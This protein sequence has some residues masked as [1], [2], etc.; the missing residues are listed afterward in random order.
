MTGG[1]PLEPMRLI[2]ATHNPAKAREV[3]RLVAGLAEVVPLPVDQPAIAAPEDGESVEEIAIAKAVFW[4]RLLNRGEF[5]VAS[6]GGL[7]IPGLGHRWNPTRTR[8]F[9]GDAATDLERAE[10]LLA[11]AADI[12]DDRRQIAWQEALAVARDGV[13]LASWTAAGDPGLL[14][15]DVDPA[16]VAAGNGFWLPAL[17]ICPECG[18]R[19]LAD[20]AP[21]ERA[22]RR[23]HWRDL[24]AALRSFLTS[25]AETPGD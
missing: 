10:A 4:S 25:I 3:A 16:A 22:A 7:V 12:P 1:G 14:A 18:G 13:L 24:G 15:G 9:A 2:V 11:L 17:W 21:A 6:D 23:D 19:R 8:R 5:V 20:L